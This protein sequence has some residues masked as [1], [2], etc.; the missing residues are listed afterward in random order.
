MERVHDI[1]G[2]ER[3]REELRGE[4]VW[5]G[6]TDRKRSG[7][8]KEEQV[9]LKQSPEHRDPCHPAKNSH[10]SHKNGW[11]CMTEGVYMPGTENPEQR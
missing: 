11:N 1:P 6:G 10:Q 8:G 9:G 5:G 7:S 2:G 3:K 4:C